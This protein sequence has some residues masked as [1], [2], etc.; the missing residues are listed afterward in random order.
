MYYYRV[1][2]HRLQWLLESDKHV[3]ALLYK[4]NE[5]FPVGKIPKSVPES[6]R[7]SYIGRY[8]T[9]MAIFTV[10]RQKPP[11][12]NPKTGQIKFQSTESHEKIQDYVWEV[13]LQ[14]EENGIATSPGS[15][16]RNSAKVAAFFNKLSSYSKDDNVEINWS[17]EE[18]V[19]DSL[20][21]WKFS[22][23]QKKLARVIDRLSL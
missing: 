11:V 15:E 2:I 18:E 17:N 7:N 4:K 12:R 5:T 8:Q 22:H 9:W 16:E 3:A 10:M 19:L 23:D 14:L 20:S 21:K 1:R 13:K 6:G